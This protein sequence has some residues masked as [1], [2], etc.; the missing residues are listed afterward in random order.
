VRDLSNTSSNGFGKFALTKED[1]ALNSQTKN[2]KI[3]D[4]EKVS[5]TKHYSTERREGIKSRLIPKSQ[6]GGKTFLHKV[7]KRE[8]REEG[9]LNAIRGVPG[10][11][12]LL[13]EENS[14]ETSWRRHGKRAYPKTEKRPCFLD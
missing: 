4:Q 3:P 2:R 14:R 5:Y 8:S 12:L 1:G 11:C 13:G 10:P 9:P 6:K 7:N